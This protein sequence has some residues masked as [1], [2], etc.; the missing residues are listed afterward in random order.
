M[1]DDTRNYADECGDHGGNEG[2]CGLPAGWGTDFDS[3]KC[4]FHRGTSPDGSSHEN[5]GNAETHGL[6]AD[7]EKWFE[8]HRDD[9]GDEVRLLVESWMTRAPF[10]WADH[11]NVWL[12]TECAIDEVRMREA[13][14][15]VDEEGLVVDH[16]D[17]HDQVSGRPIRE[18]KE[19]PA[20]L[21]K[22]RMK[23]DTVRTL[24]DL[25]VLDDPESQ[26]A[27]ELGQLADVWRDDLEGE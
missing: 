10:G 8:R 7:A 24:K 12:L 15:Y 11:G 26:K 5:N 13:D 19:N 16:Y 6:T 25:G 18:Y 20:L 22:S 4:K 2:S 1:T 27:T 14:D 21:P 3:G 23:K 17:G 9:V